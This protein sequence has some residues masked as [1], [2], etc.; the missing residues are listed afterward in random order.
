M[1]KNYA[2][3]LTAIDLKLKKFYAKR[4][5]L[6]LEE[7]F[8]NDGWPVSFNAKIPPYFE[9]EGFRLLLKENGYKVKTT[10]NGLEIHKKVRP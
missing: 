4:V 7:H 6:E 1:A 5:L 10:P 8:T 9:T 3:E 2:A